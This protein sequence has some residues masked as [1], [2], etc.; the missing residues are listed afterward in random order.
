[1]Q[2]R[3]QDCGFGRVSRVTGYERHFQSFSNRYKNPNPRLLRRL[4]CYRKGRAALTAGE[5][6]GRCCPHRAQ[7]RPH[8]S[9]RVSLAVSFRGGA[10][11]LH[12]GSCGKC[13]KMCR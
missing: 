3:R 12:G 5:A 1:M 7:L 6:T 11:W 13:S 2:V 10:A 8:E 9:Q 4:L